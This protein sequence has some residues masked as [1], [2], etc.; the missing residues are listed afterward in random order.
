MEVDCTVNS[1]ISDVQSNDHEVKSSP[2]VIC[3]ENT[4]GTPTTVEHYSDLYDNRS[5]KDPRNNLESSVN[6]S[7]YSSYCNY[8]YISTEEPCPTSNKGF[9]KDVFTK[10]EESDTQFCVNTCQSL[11]TVP[12]VSKNTIYRNVEFTSDNNETVSAVES[13]VN[14]GVDSSSYNIPATN[15]ISSVV[16][17]NHAST[18]ASEFTKIFNYQRDTMSTPDIT[19]RNDGQ[20]NLKS[21]PD[22]F[23]LNHCEDLHKSV[24][25]RVDHFTNDQQKALHGYIESGNMS[26]CPDQQY[27][28]SHAY[29]NNYQVKEND[30]KPPYDS[31]FFEVACNAMNTHSQNYSSKDFNYANSQ[32]S[33]I[34]YVSSYQDSNQSSESVSPCV[35]RSSF[36]P[37][38]HSYYWPWVDRICAENCAS[39]LGSVYTSDLSSKGIVNNANSNFASPYNSQSLFINGTN[40]SYISEK[41]NEQSQ[42][43]NLS[44]VNLCTGETM[45]AF[46]SIAQ[47]SSDYSDASVI[48]GNM[49]NIILMPAQSSVDVSSQSVV[50]S[51]KESQAD[52]NSINYS[53]NSWQ[54][55]MN[56]LQC[57]SHKRL[58]NKQR[59]TVCVS[60]SNEDR[61]EESNIPQD[62]TSTSTHTSSTYDMSNLHRENEVCLS[63]SVSGNNYVWSSKSNKVKF[64]SRGRS[65]KY[66]DAINLTRNRPLNETAL[67][68]MESWYTNH[69]DNPYPTTA[70]KEQLAALGGITVIQV[71]S[72]FA[73]RRTRTANTKPK[74]NRRK[75]YHQIY[76][77]AV[78]IEAMTQGALRASDLQERIGQI[79][80]EYLT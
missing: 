71:S 39:K 5:N 40:L 54:P 18:V 38:A 52:G 63:Q 58:T 46:H 60:M 72:W 42:S 10:A 11:Y 24:N 53:E 28:Q 19:Q 36:Y 37:Q 21:D 69:V 12:D 48:P 50:I 44:A 78:E 22:H 80:D 73:N 79:I 56:S 49:P 45:S 17:H 74:K 35:K 23:W 32:N 62:E 9:I 68:V 25:R 61:T 77:L 55:E 6:E 16:H 43:S 34:D 3:Y 67:S 47:M 2:T 7:G 75:L 20:R 57:S 15:M 13:I 8:S 66:T 33:V 31:N 70:E 30:S 4:I 65:K 29:L 26:T 64:N 1:P 27:A 41:S 14:H 51:H 76:Q 59:K